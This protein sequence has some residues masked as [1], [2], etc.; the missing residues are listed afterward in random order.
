MRLYKLSILAVLCS[1]WALAFAAP[2]SF[3]PL[4][5]TQPDGSVIDIYASGDEFHNWLHDA[6]NYTIV[7]NDQGFYVYAESRGDNLVAGSLVVGRDLPSQRSLAPGLMISQDAIR[8][9]YD[10]YN[11]TMRDY[12]NGRSPHTGQFNNL[13]VFIKFADSPEFTQPITN[14][15]NMFNNANP[16]ANSMKNYFQAASY[17]QLNVDSFFYPAPNG[18]AVVSWTDTNPRGYYSPIS[19]SN[20]IGYDPDDDDERAYRE[21]TLLA[22][23]IAGIAPSIPESLVLDG[24]SDGYIDNVC[25]IVQGSPD[26]WAELLWPHRWVLYGADAYINGALVWDFNFQLENSLNSSGASVLSHE[27]FHSLGAPDL[28]RYYDNTINPIGG[29]DLMASN[30][31]PPQH[32]SA[33][34][35]YRYGQWLTAPPMITQSGEYSLSPVASSSTNN[36]YRVPSWRSNESYILEYR[37]PGAFYDNNLP[38]Y[39]LL[40]YRLDAREEGNASG[41]P[42][43]L[44]LYRPYGTNTTTNGTI[45]MA[46]YSANANR[47]EIS[48]VTVPNGFLGN[49]G[50]GG[51]NLYDIGFTNDTITFKIKISDLQL[52]YPHGGETWFYG[53][54]KTITWKAKNSTGSVKLEYSTDGGANWSTIV[55]STLNT[56]SYVWQ[57]VPLVDSATCHVKITHLTSGHHDSNYYAF[58]IIS[59]LGVP[60]PLSPMGGDMGSPTNPLLS[61]T[62]VIGAV[63][64][65]VQLSTDPGFVSNVVNLLGHPTNSYQVSGLQP[66]TQYWW[67]VAAEGEQGEGPFCPDQAFTTGNV[68]E[69]PAVPTQVS[70]V[71]NT[72]NVPLNVTLRWNSAYL[73]DEYH[74]QVSASPYFGTMAYENTAV[75]GTSVVCD[76][77]S[78][79]T[80]YYWRVRSVNPAGF[81]NYSGNRRF[82]TGT[83]VDND[84]EVTSPAI[85]SL[86]Q[87][88]PNPFN[89]TTT[90]SFTVKDP[91][92]LVDVSIYNQRGQLVR[93][94]FSGVP[95][96]NLI[97]LVWDGTDDMGSAVGT[98]L[99]LYRMETVGYTETRKMI[100]IK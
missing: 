31:N 7:K 75:S 54:N 73:A 37:K 50:A 29:W 63:G 81:S 83:A 85:N 10:R 18:T 99:Y 2:H 72:T 35:K 46:A 9:K 15:D 64:Y 17:Q 51:L 87:N 38:G 27:M 94:L 30:A 52:T 57:G 44:Y 56:G 96:N 11:G 20:P 71:N 86:A 55:A 26:G 22:N 91:A 80:S 53:T 95:H 13:V 41:P 40:V 47:T 74:V 59:Q 36:I 19:G 14:Y 25:F 21:F 77:L 98:G 12:S 28:Y 92:G 5:F 97:T 62:E 78:P 24:D 65:N 42:D 43:E 68:S 84:D 32:M 88:Y 58:R 79:N 8:R 69:L 49:N 16:G 89:P 39:G 76:L 45:S 4:Q 70:P 48:E 82:T 100:M 66:Y 93:R 61:W 23:C 3:L 67:R 34:M 33:W 90:I 6:E 60:E 1:L